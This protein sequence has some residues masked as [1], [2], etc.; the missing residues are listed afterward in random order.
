L[1]IF[2]C[3]GIIAMTAVLLSQTE[4]GHGLRGHLPWLLEVLACPCCRDPEP[5]R[6]RG[7]VRC[8][9][10]DDHFFLEGGIV[11]ARDQEEPL[12]FDVQRKV[13]E[14]L[15]K[16]RGTYDLPMERLLLLPE[17][18]ET[19]NVLN[20]LRA[21]SRTRGCLRV[22]QLSA[23][24][25]W[26]ANALAED[27]HQVVTGD[28]LDDPYIGLGC[29]VRLR[30]HTGNP[31]ACVR[32][33]TT[34][35]PFLRESFDGVFCFDALKSVPDIER[36]F[37]E[38]GRVLRPGGLFLALQ[39]PFRGA[40][41]TQIQRLLDSNHYRLA[42]WWLP[43]K[44]DRT[45]DPQMVYL[46]SQL[47]AS[48]HE[49]RRRVPF[50]VTQGESAGLQTTVL[51]TA[52]ALQL[53]SELKC[54]GT[55]EATQPAWV[56]SLAGVYALDIHR[57]HAIIERARQSLGYDLI[58]ELLNHWRLLG[59]IEGVLLARKDRSQPSDF[60]SSG[61]LDP[62]RS[63][64]LDALLLAC[65]T[66]GFVPIH[67]VHPVQVEGQDR[68]CWIQPQAGLLVPAGSSLEVTIRCPGKPFCDAP[69]R[70]EFRLETERL[71]LAVVLVDAGGRVTFKLP[72][73]ASLMRHGSL[74]IGITSNFGFLPSDFNP[75]PGGD[76]RLLAVQLHG[77]RPAHSPPEDP[78]AV[79]HQIVSRL[80]P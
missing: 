65:A 26:A 8:P 69:V 57:L 67:G 20:W 1:N 55:S 18:Q 46:R 17:E 14:S 44:L 19:R 70:I 6:T 73:P 16:A 60:T 43:G 5:G 79:L 45:A 50:C 39:E 63:R 53:S 40:L 62:E 24:R 31:F 11:Y 35:L 48:K 47:G 30:D 2:A 72:I 33:G 61:P 64:R 71:P 3:E 9:H 32:T 75:G 42:R 66:D 68:Y 4:A 51:P 76:T 34:D 80:T 78:D 28:L 52:V 36:F 56:D 74:F 54:P 27:G 7:E 23:G 15:E 29:A 38:V 21:Q 12:H 49:M 25:G 22:L 58:P 41:T 77:V 13:V 37:Q 59:N 10:V